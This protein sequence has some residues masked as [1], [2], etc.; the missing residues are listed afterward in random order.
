MEDP[1]VEPLTGSSSPS[2]SDR[3]SSTLLLELCTG[4]AR[5]HLLLAEADEGEYRAVRG[6]LIALEGL[7]GGLPKVPAR[8]RKIGFRI[9]TTPPQKR[10]G[11]KSGIKRR[12]RRPPR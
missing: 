9:D 8:S 5:L 4:V 10:S 7:V 3:E 12:R 1:P 11:I 2:D 6:R